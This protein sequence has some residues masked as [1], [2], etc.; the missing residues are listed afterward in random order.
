MDIPLWWCCLPLRERLC[1]SGL[2]P[3]FAGVLY[4]Y[5]PRQLFDVYWIGEGDSI[6]ARRAGFLEIYLLRIVTI[7]VEGVPTEVVE[8]GNPLL[9]ALWSVWSL[10]PAAGCPEGCQKP[11]YS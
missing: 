11:N 6:A 8:C 1:V 2:A 5:L 4:T 10:S 3:A 9:W 7:D